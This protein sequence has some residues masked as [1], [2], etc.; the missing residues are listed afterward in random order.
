MSDDLTRI[1]EAI[2]LSWATVRNI[3]QNLVI[4]LLTV[5]ALLL[6]VLFGKVAMAGAA[7]VSDIMAQRS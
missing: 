5:S 6:W 7:G 2:R 4:A 3:R 1:P